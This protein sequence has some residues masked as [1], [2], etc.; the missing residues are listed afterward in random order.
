MFSRSEAAANGIQGTEVTERFL[1]FVPYRNDGGFHG[2]LTRINLAF[3]DTLQGHTQV[4]TKGRG[5]QFETF[6]K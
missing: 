1:N 4:G 6:N 2:L 3:F 5:R